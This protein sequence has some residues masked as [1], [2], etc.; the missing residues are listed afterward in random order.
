MR[1]SSSWEIIHS[2]RRIRPHSLRMNPL[3]NPAP[4]SRTVKSA[5]HNIFAISAVEYHS[6]IVR[7]LNKEIQ[8]LLNPLEP[9]G[10]V[11]VKFGLHGFLNLQVI[12]RAHGSGC[13]RLSP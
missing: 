8:H 5:L 7:L 2:R 12:Y 13:A 3:P 11:F 1:T 10:H 6:F 9:F 4:H